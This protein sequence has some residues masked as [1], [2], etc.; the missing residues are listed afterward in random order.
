MPILVK[1]NFEINK[2]EV[3]EDIP[4]VCGSFNEWKY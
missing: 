1:D 2:K 3:N 4:F